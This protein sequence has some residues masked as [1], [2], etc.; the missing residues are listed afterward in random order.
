MRLM[1]SRDDRRSRLPLS[2]WLMLWDKQNAGMKTGAGN[3]FDFAS[4]ALILVVL[5][6]TSKKSGP[7][8][9]GTQANVLGRGRHAERLRQPLPAGGVTVPADG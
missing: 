5:W 6:Q 7:S 3:P 1:K 8:K 2:V 4:V 9:P